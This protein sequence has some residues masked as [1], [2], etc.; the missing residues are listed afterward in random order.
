MGMVNPWKNRQEG[1]SQGDLNTSNQAAE[2]ARSVTVT[3]RLILDHRRRVKEVWSQFCSFP[4]VSRWRLQKT[5]AEMSHFPRWH[6]VRE[7]EFA[8]QVDDHSVFKLL[9]HVL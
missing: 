2:R 6:A 8:H 7:S 1:V 5:R 9:V 3:H 4:S